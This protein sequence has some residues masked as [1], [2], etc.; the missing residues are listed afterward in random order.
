[1][2]VKMG[3]RWGINM[4]VTVLAM[5]VLNPNAEK[6]L[7]TYLDVIGPLMEKAGA[8]IIS[9]H[10]VIE[11]ITGQDV[12]KFITLVG[13]PSRAAVDDVFEHDAYHAI[14]SVRDQ[15]FQRYDICVL[16]P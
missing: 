15:A 6:A 12:P 1:M 8:Q 2:H 16:A 5:T 14:K 9:Q 4:P 13:Y 7:T 3:V 10:E 11:T